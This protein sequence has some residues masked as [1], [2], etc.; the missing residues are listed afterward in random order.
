VEIWLEF[1]SRNHPGYRDFVLNRENLSQLPVDDSVFDQLSIHEV[2]SLDSIGTDVSLLVEP[3]AELEDDQEC[4]EAAVPNLLINDTE[5]AQLQGRVAN[6]VVENVEQPPL[7]PRRPQ[8]AHQLSMPTIRRSPLNEFNKSQ[9]LLSLACPGLYPRGMADFTDPRQRTISYQD[10]LEHAMKWEDGRFARHHTFRFIALNTLA[11]QQ[12]HGQSKYYVNKQ[13]RTPMTKA[14]L[15][16]ALDNPDRPE[17][18]A[19]LNRISRYAGVIKGTRPYWYR[20]RRECESF[21]HCLGSPNA[22]ITLSPADL[23]WQSLY[24]HMPEYDRWQTADEPA[25]MALSRRL[26]RENPHIAAW[27]FH[28]RTRLFRDIVLKEKFNMEDFWSRFE[29][30]GRGSSHAHGLYWFKGSPPVE[31]TEPAEREEFARVWGYHVSAINPE[32]DQIGRGGDGG[33]PLSV[34][35]LETDITWEWLSRILNRCQRHH[36]STAYCLRIN[37]KAA[38]Q[39]RERGEQA[40]EPECRFLFPRQPRE[41]AE[42]IRHPGKTWWSFEGRRNDTLMNQYNRLITLAWLANTDISPCS[43]VEAVINYAAKYCSKTEQQ[44]ASYAEIAKAILPHVSDRNPMLSFVSKMMNKLIGERDYSAQEI[45]RLRLKLLLQE[46][47]RAVLSVDCRPQDKHTRPL[48]FSDEDE[49]VQEKQTTYEKY[50]NP[51]PSM[52]DVSVCG[53]LEF[54]GP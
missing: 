47:S 32:P 18:Q 24:Q 46:D 39:A 34:N 9:P 22:F 38:E 51:P 26:L 49:I 25:R 30:Q 54:P 48:D 31:M 45:R 50:C 52:E 7:E 2:D 1:L 44:T 8:D 10:Y 36:C 40:P 14:E 5:L 17:A 16:A 37:K 6:E 23:H 33:N 53:A 29:W 11:R 20:R 13:Q 19:I 41:T 42:M 21:A 12:A 43:G 3:S 4:D 35:S 15:Q 27:H 28:S